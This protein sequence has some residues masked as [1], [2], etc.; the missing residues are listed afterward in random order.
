VVRYTF[1]PLYTLQ[2]SLRYPLDVR[3]G[4]SQNR[5]GRSAK[6]LEDKLDGLAQPV[7]RLGNGADDQADEVR[8][9]TEAADFLLLNR[10]LSLALCI[11]GSQEIVGSVFRVAGIFLVDK[12]RPARM[13]GIAPSVSRLSKQCRSLDASQP[14]GPPRLVTPYTDICKDDLRL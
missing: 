13:A 3:V 14:C 12:R 10:V 11:H 4:R 6:S 7:Q 1:S 5:C 2:R 8:F 9:H